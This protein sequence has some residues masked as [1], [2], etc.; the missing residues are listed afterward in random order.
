[1]KTASCTRRDLKVVLVPLRSVVF[2][3]VATA[4]MA[5]GFVAFSK[6]ALAEELPRSPFA[7]EIPPPTKYPPVL[8]S[9][10]SSLPDY[11]MRSSQTVF[12]DPGTDY[13]G[14]SAVVANLRR[15]ETIRVF[16][17]DFEVAG[18][19]QLIEMESEW[20]LPI[21]SQYVYVKLKR[22]EGR[23]QDKFIVVQDK[24]PLKKVSSSQDLSV[25]GHLIK[26]KAEIRL[27]RVL[28][29]EDGDSA[30]EYFRAQITRTLD[31]SEAGDILLRGTI[32]SALLDGK[33]SQ[34][35]IVAD[36]MGGESE[37]RSG[38]FG[39]GSYVF[40]NKGADDGVKVGD[41]MPIYTDRRLR[42]PK[43]PIW[44]SPLS[45][46]LVKVVHVASGVATG[47][48]VKA[49]APLRQGDK[50]GALAVNSPE[51]EQEKDDSTEDELEISE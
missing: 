28:Q 10:P 32:Q 26:V 9:L 36:I 7:V 40:I 21:S 49:Q 23:L 31:M 41:L 48:V 3:S 22:G 5:S 30:Y 33:G 8:P 2:G 1:M 24:G 27:E 4:L 39:F 51:P 13:A 29:P 34:S 20:G 19:G 37:E 12:E 44:N 46:G 18:S 15:V 45:E 25:K 11:Q 14:L 35:S 47:L 38:L 17:A 50:T 6:T 43:T 42:S 16:A